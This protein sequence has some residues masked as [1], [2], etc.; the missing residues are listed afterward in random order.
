MS[1][2][3][4][5]VAHTEAG[6]IE[7]LYCGPDRLAAKTALEEG[8]GSPITELFSFIERTAVRKHEAAKEALKKKKQN[9]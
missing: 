8:N 2:L 9:G 7:V 1:R 3:H 4:L 5:T 6:G